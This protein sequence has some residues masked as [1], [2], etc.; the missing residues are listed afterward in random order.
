[1]N[2][3]LTKLRQRK[4][5]KEVSL[6]DYMPQ[7]REDGRHLMP[8]VDWSQ[9]IDK[10]VVG[11]EINRIICEAI[12][13]L[14][15]MDRAVLIM[16]DLEEMSNLEIGKA[17]GLSVEAVKSRLHRVRLCLRGKLSSSLRS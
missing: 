6:D 5:G 12:D 16:S 4:R 7:F 3:A 8:V 14:P 10:L 15:H 17:L 13:Q 2:A 11:N 1:M 9:D